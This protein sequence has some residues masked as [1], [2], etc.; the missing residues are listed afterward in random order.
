MRIIPVIHDPDNKY[1]PKNYLIGG[2]CNCTSKESRA[3][4]PESTEDGERATE[5]ESTKGRSE[6]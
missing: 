4:M 6:P 1:C 5:H 2:R 3:Y